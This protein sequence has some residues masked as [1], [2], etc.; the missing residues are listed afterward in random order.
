MIPMNQST[1]QLEAEIDQYFAGV[2]ASQLAADLKEANFDYFNKIGRKVF[3]KRAFGS[4]PIS[5]PPIET[6]CHQEPVM[7]PAGATDELPLAA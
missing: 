4:L 3:I 2:T 6:T 1:Q 5:A 7:S